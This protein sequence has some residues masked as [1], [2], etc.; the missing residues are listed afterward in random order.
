MVRC[1]FWW[2][3][4]CINRTENK[5]E[6]TDLMLQIKEFNEKWLISPMGENKKR[7]CPRFL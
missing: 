5:Q 3:T 6:F 7:G 2:E 4:V 1:I